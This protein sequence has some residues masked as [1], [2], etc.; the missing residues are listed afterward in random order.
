MDPWSYTA[1]DTGNYPYLSLSLSL[2]LSFLLSSLFLSLSLSLI[3]SLSHHSQQDRYS[4]DIPLSRKQ[5][6]TQQDRR[7]RIQQVRMARP[8]EPHIRPS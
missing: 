8:Y 6:E 4:L 7:H 1:T 2:S 5:K 3:L